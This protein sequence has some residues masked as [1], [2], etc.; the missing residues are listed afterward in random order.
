MT[1]EVF[2]PSTICLTQPA[3]INRN[4]RHT[5]AEPLLHVDI[6][7]SNMTSN[8]EASRPNCE[9]VA[10]VQHRVPYLFFTLSWYKARW[11]LLIRPNH[12]HQKGGRNH[13]NYHCFGWMSWGALALYLSL[14]GRMSR[15][16]LEL[17]VYECLYP[18]I[19]G[20]WGG[21]VYE[22]CRRR[23]AWFRIGLW[24]WSWRWGDR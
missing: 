10:R 6:W 14:A 12:H 16:L 5:R 15:V 22:C 11:R 7:P 19:L 23:T 20:C 8:A 17:S 24:I 18:M 4:L 1:R 13:V 2:L 9:Y 3:S 21:S